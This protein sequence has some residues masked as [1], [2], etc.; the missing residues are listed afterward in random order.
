M[1]I[2][3]IVVGVAVALVVGAYLAR[4]FRTTEADLD[5]SI[6]A[7]GTQVRAEGAAARLTDRRPEPMNF[8]PQ[9][10]KTHKNM[11]HSC[12]EA[13]KGANGGSPFSKL[14]GI[15]PKFGMKKN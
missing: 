4:P 14:A 1:D 11:C 9:C 13:K 2:G 5:Q 6:D 12:L 7:W 15:I 3:S 10:G 8:C